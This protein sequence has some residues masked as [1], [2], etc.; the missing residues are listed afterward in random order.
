MVRAEEL[1]ERPT[2]PEGY[3]ALI[4]GLGGQAHFMHRIQVREERYA[5]REGR[6]PRKDHDFSSDVSRA[7]EIAD[8]LA[9]ELEAKFGIIHP[10]NCPKPDAD[11]KYPDPPEGKQWYRPWFDKMREQWL[12]SEFDKHICS[13]C[14]FNEGIGSFSY[15]IPCGSPARG[16]LMMNRLVR[17][18]VCGLVDNEKW[19]RKE[20]LAAIEEKGGKEGLRLFLEKEQALTPKTGSVAG[21]TATEEVPDFG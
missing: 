18:H 5:S 12:Q 6:E 1:P 15:R 8:I 3:F 21:T 2:T 13:S 9:T 14:P 4:D 16:G 19:T 11:G 7:H 17:L 20:M 10:K